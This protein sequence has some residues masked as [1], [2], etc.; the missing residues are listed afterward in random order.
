MHR[1]TVLKSLGA[2]SMAVLMPKI[3]WSATESSRPWERVLVLVELAGGNDGLNTVVPYADAAYYSARPRLAVGRSEVLHLDERVGLN[4][5]L[6]PL[7]D[8]YR[9]KEAAVVLGVGYPH[10]NRSHFRSIDIWETGSDANEVLQDGW[11]ARQLVS[12]LPKSL[13]ADGVVIGRGNTGA[14]D[15]AN[16]DTV[17]LD[18]PEQFIRQARQLRES[19]SKG[20]GN[21]ALAHV[22]RVQ[23]DTL[24]AAQV[25]E[26]QRGRG[27]TLKTT[28]PA[29]PLG[30]QM[31]NAARLIADEIPVA[32]IKVTHVG[33]DTHIDQRR[34]HDVLL[35]QFAEA[36]AAFR[37]AMIETGHWQRTLV[38]TYSEFGRRV[39]QNGNNGTDH[40]T[41]APHFIFGGRVLGGIY[42]E[43][44]GLL[45]LD[46]EDMSHTV[47]FRRMYATVAQRWWGIS[48]DIFGAEGFTPL[49]CVT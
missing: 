46:G 38:M 26:S 41:A 15:G 18:R 28:F 40:G 32:V 30:Q 8:I 47:D 4:P 7:M 3:A 6:R 49:P 44:P 22:L 39:A 31:H 17:V 9:A 33:F 23:N 36:I 34:R 21:A 45:R 2:A 12:R 11:V 48:D 35:A 14:L 16:F 20:G 10:P 43:Q 1:R 25:L 5:N 29:T 42:G 24:K 37:S 19:A 13:A 27:A